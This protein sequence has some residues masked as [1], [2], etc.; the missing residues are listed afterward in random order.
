MDVTES[1]IF[2]TLVLVTGFILLSS[3]VFEVRRV[4]VR[5][6]YY[7]SEEMILSVADVGLGV[8]IY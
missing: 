4:L 3:P 6:N 2:I 8:N 5:G 1:I 7:L